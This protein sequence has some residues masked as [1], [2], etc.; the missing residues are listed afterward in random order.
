MIADTALALSIL[1]FSV[2][3]AMAIWVVDYM[4]KDP[5]E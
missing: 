4:T 1:A 5:D 2:S 3:V